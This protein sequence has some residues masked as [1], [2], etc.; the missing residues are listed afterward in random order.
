[1][2][3]DKK[4]NGPLDKF[5]EDYEELKRR[6]TILER[7]ISS[8]SSS[9]SYKKRRIDNDDDNDRNV[10]KIE[11]IPDNIE[12]QE[13]RDLATSYGQLIRFFFSRNKPHFAECTYKRKTD[14]DRIIEDAHKIGMKI[15]YK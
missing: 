11:D 8:S 13:M 15:Y 3:N 4:M 7:V 6:V 12:Y 10:V 1:M 9:S 5:V 2:Q 14:S